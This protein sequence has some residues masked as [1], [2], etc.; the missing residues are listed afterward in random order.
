[1]QTIER[2]ESDDAAVVAEVLKL[3]KRSGWL[4]WLAGILAAAVIALGA[5]LIVDLTS[6]SD[7]AL[8][9]DVQVALDGYTAGWESHDGSAAMTFATDDYT[10]VNNGRSFSATQQ[11]AAINMGSSLSFRV[12]VLD[13]MATGDD[14]FYVTKTEHIHMTGAPSEGYPGV[15][16]YTLVQVD[17]TWKIQQHQ[18]TGDI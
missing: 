7:A 2:V 14:P 13:T 11:A 16:V 9:D 1:M 18:W 15:S 12:E 10:F 5:W 17:G 6:G 3:R 8:P 4:G